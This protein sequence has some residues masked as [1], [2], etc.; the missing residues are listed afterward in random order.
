MTLA[1]WEFI[2]SEAACGHP[3]LQIVEQ[4]LKAVLKHFG[5]FLHR[6]KLREAHLLEPVIKHCWFSLGAGLSGL[7]SMHSSELASLRR[8]G[9][10]ARVGPQ[11]HPVRRSNGWGGGFACACRALLSNLLSPIHRFTD[12]PIHRFTDSPIHRF[13]DSPI[14]RFTG[15][16]KHRNTTVPS[17]MKAGGRT[18]GRG[19]EVQIDGQFII[20]GRKILLPS[21]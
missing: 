3:V 8:Q 6:F 13:T 9:R 7:N 17:G 1:I 20:R 2:P 19:K 21:V 16:P 4:S 5:D 11:P 18:G 15:L 12:S 14:H 10:R